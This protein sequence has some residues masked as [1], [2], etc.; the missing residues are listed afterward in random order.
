MS[1]NK[2]SCRK[3]LSSLEPPITLGER[4]FSYFSAIILVRFF[5]RD[6]NLLNCELENF[7][8]KL[9]C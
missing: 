3:L 6:F 2:S 7:S 1:V 4:Y 8:F 9:L 5:I